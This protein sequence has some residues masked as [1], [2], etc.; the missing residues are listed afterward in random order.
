MSFS[1]LLNQQNCRLTADADR[2]ADDTLVSL[3]RMGNRTVV[4]MVTIM[5][6]LFS[7]VYKV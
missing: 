3:A 4:V 5:L 7:S 6:L 1:I 2:K